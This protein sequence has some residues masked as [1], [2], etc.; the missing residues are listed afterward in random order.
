M[1]SFCWRIFLQFSKQKEDQTC[2]WRSKWVVF[3]TGR[4]NQVMLFAYLCAVG[5][6][7]SQVVLFR[8][9]H[10]SLTTGLLRT[11]S[12]CNQYLKE[13]YILIK[14][15]FGFQ[16]KPCENEQE[17]FIFLLQICKICTFFVL[18]FFGIFNTKIINFY[19]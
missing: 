3:V 1:C 18:F 5:R 9:F 14:F 4:F 8:R 2:S 11:I 10:R 12:L 17:F 15:G 13:G 16:I 7:P 6:I 19:V